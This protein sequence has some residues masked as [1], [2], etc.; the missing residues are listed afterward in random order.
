MR[1]AKLALPPLIL[2]LSAT[3]GCDSGKK[4]RTAASAKPTAES[5]PT[6]PAKPKGPP[7]FVVNSVG[8]KVGF[9]LIVLDKPDGP[10]RLD[11]EL[12]ENKSYIDG[13][14]V[15]VKADRKS[16]MKSV[17]M[18]LS[19]LAKDGAKTVTIKTETREEYQDRT[20]F[21]P[22]SEITDP[23]PC[24]VVAMVLDDRSSAVW[25]LSGTTAIRH[26]KG[27][28]GP[29]LSMTGDVIER[30]AKSCKKSSTIFV[31]AADNIEWG[32]AYD[33]AA[34]TQKIKKVKFDHVV[35]LQQTPTAGRKVE[36]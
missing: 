14:D 27:L 28:A 5:V 7:Q 13:K 18:M 9:S 22:Q 32:L 24:S 31:A 23:A 20:K 6:E 36:L 35:L 2:A 3:A 1:L 11:T 8:A 17:I 25:H 26:A 34:S 16:K 10:G 4:T 12:A 15:L 21:T 33:L 30:L 19:A 29:D